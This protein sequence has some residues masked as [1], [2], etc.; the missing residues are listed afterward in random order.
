MTNGRKIWG[1]F[2]LAAAILVVIGLI[3]F[4]STRR[5]IDANRL[6]SH[7]QEVLTTLDNLVSAIKDIETSQRGYIITGSEASLGPYTAALPDLEQASKHLR[8]LAADYPEQQR[9]LDALEPVI[10]ARLR[11]LRQAVD[12]RNT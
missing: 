10:A 4:W 5:L 8:T 3:S 2:G 1:G 12:A 6:V 11:E 9:R 7:T